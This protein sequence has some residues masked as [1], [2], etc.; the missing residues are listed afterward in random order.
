[1]KNIK[2]GREKSAK[3]IERNAGNSKRT[4]QIGGTTWWVSN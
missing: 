3:E 4:H 2:E 1:M